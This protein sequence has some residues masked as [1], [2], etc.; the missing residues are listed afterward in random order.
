MPTRSPT[1][2]YKELAKA[3]KELGAELEYILHQISLLPKQ[4]EI[5][6][7]ARRTMKRMIELDQHKSQGRKRP[8]SPIKRKSPR[9]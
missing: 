7:D 6:E 3:R 9:K 1:R 5:N 8:K 4:V 2:S